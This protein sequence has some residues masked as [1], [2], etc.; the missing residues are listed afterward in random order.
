ML[1]EADQ[2][3]LRRCR[4]TYDRPDGIAGWPDWASSLLPAKVPRQGYRQLESG[5]YWMFWSERSFAS[6]APGRM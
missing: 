5:E 3:A 2:H 6:D 1:T 4:E